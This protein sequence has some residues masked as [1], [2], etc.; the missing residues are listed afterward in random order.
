MRS[1]NQLIRIIN[2]RIPKKSG[3]G[4]K[5]S[6]GK[7]VVEGIGKDMREKEKKGSARGTG[8]KK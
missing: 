5:D 3:L 8:E 1:L 2:G 6:P 4:R 7:K